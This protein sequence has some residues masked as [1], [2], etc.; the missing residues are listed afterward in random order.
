[1]TNG[2][3]T[4][5]DVSVVLPTYNR[6]GVLREAIESVLHQTL[7]AREILVVDDGS[8]D[9][10]R[11]LVAAL[12]GPIRYLH[13]PNKGPG[14]ARNLGL[15]VAEGEWIAFQDSDDRWVPDKT[16]RQAAFLREHPQLDFVFGHLSNFEGNERTTPT[17]TPEIL[18]ERLYA[19]L[20]ANSARLGDGFFRELLRSNPI[21][22]PTVMFRRACLATVG[23]FDETLP[24]CEDYDLWLRFAARCCCGFLDEVLVER[25]I[26]GG[27]L[28]HDYASMYERML[29][30]L[31]RLPARLEGDAKTPAEWQSALAAARSR[32]HHRLGAWYFSK[33]RW[34]EA[35]RHLRAVKFRA[36]EAGV[37]ERVLFLLK[38]LLAP[39]LGRI[40]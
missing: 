4:A 6:V 21:P 31:E 26:H 10:T 34:A 12:R 19:Y 8:T 9:G 30:V 35:R 32:T 15:R 33:R 39:M 28:V 37:R 18:D 3:A 40:A 20:K 16:A 1:M 22:T 27:N 14:A 23:S 2:R 29:T 36:L 11:E 13:Q 17:A 7:P 5:F 24:I 25:R 38:R